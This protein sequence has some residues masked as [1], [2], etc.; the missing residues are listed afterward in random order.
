M[1]VAMWVKVNTATYYGGTYQLPTLSVDYDNGTIITTTATASTS[2][3]L[4]TL[5]FTPTTTYPEIKIN[6]G[7]YTDA[8][9]TDSY[10]YVDDVSVLFPAGT[11]LNLGTLDTWAR[12][13]PIAPSISTTITAADVWNVATVGLTGGGTTGKLLVDT[14][15]KVDDA[16]VLRGIM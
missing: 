7:G 15:I 12:A 11:V 8:T 16:A 10:F 2:W 1:T 13:K 4:L 3:Q 6:I 14:E 9:G 5:N